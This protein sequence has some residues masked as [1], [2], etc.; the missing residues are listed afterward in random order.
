MRGSGIKVNSALKN[1]HAISVQGWIDRDKGHGFDGGLGDEDAIEEITMMKW[2]LME[3]KEM[4]QFDGQ[5]LHMVMGECLRNCLLQVRR[6]K[7][8]FQAGF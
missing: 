6:G 5:Q 3:T 4:R 2:Q 1:C 7:I 8:T